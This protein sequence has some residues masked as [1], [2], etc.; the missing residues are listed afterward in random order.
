MHER[1]E[2]MTFIRE[3]I[4]ELRLRKGVSEHRMS[5]DLDKS[6]GYIRTITNG[7]AVPSVRVLLD[8]IS[9]LG[10]DPAE[11]F[12]PLTEEDSTYRRLCERLRALNEEDLEKVLIFLNWIGR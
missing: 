11:F 1:N 2:E 6:G 4:T 5:L 3:R 7:L 9:Y 12:A 10:V 8:I